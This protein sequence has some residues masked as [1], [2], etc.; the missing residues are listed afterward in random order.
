MFI[1][2]MFVLVSSYMPPP[3]PGVAPPVQWG[4]PHVVR[5]RLGDSVKDLAFRRGVLTMPALSPQHARAGMERTA[6]PVIKLVQMLTASDPAKLEAFRREYEGI[7]GDFLAENVVTQDYLM[8]R[9][10]KK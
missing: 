3:P 7:V 5:E 2:K 4:E 9:A 6:G 8:T 10:T 1:G